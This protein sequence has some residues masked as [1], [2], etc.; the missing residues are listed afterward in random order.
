MVLNHLMGLNIQMV[1]IVLCIPIFIWSLFFYDKRQV[2]YAAFSYGMFTFYIGIINKIFTGFVTDCIVATV[3]G[4]VMLGIAQGIILK[5]SVANGPESIVGIYLKEKKGMS[6]GTFFLILNTVIISSSILYGNITMIIYSLMCNAIASKVT[7]IVII[8]TKKYYIVR[9][10]S[11]HY[12]DITEYISKELQRSVT[13]IQ[14]MDTSNVQ[15]KM[16]LETVISKRELLKL[17]EYIKDIK[18]DSF[19]YVTES[20][21]LMGKKFKEQL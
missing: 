5:Q 1:L 3:T 21:G 10:M 20:A 15:K 9:V 16:L 2:F 19:V 13:F 12:L 7:D 18:D 8:G 17:K 11:D 14:G 4:G 6:V